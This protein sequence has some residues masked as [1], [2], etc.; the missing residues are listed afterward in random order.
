MN[1]LLTALFLEL[2]IDLG[3]IATP[4]HVV[5]SASQPYICTVSANGHSG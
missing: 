5:C 4:V 3:L 1:A 2:D